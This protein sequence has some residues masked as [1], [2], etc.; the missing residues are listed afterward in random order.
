MSA[1]DFLF[2]WE[3]RVDQFFTIDVARSVS[4]CSN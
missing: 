3:Y 1:A 4:V 2:P